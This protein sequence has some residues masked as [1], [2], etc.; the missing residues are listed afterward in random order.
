MSNITV[1]EVIYQRS[2]FALLFV[3]IIMY[4]SNVSFLELDKDLFKYAA[5]RIFGSA[6]G[7]IFQIF[8]LEMIPISKAVILIYNPFITAIT[9]YLCIGEQIY[10]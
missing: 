5:V 3:I 4:M 10:R 7:F 9:T 6:L 8:S 1:F 2:F